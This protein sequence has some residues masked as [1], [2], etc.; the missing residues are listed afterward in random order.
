MKLE[1]DGGIGPSTSKYPSIVL[2][3]GDTASLTQLEF[4]ASL[5]LE[6]LLVPVR[7][8]FREF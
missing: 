4:D 5:W 3:V 8:F 1:P 2:E 6:H 7:L